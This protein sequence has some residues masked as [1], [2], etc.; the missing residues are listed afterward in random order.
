MLSCS[1]LCTAADCCLVALCA[2][3]LIAVWLWAY[4][5]LYNMVLN[6][7]TLF[8]SCFLHSLILLLYLHCRWACCRPVP[9]PSSLRPA[10]CR[11]HFRRLQATPPGRSARSA[12]PTSL[13]A[14][15]LAASV[16]PCLSN[17]LFTSS[18]AALSL[19]R[20]LPS[21]SLAAT[22]A[23]DHSLANLLLSRCHLAV[24][25]FSLPYCSFCPPW[26]FLA[27]RLTITAVAVGH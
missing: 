7:Q 9:P 8:L 27:R 1:S 14:L 17:S 21:F 13:T 22:L 15:S 10:T 12:C 5:W 23:L 2:L 19:A 24:T 20:Q 4:L 6:G 25:L 16:A 3:L 18:L 26:I 11:L